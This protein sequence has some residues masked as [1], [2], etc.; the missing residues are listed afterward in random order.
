MEVEPKVDELP[1]HGPTVDFPYFEHLHYYDRVRDA[2]LNISYS[3]IREFTFGEFPRELPKDLD[4]NWTHTN[5]PE[6]LRKIIAGR[7]GT[8]ADHHLM[9]TGANEGNLVVNAALGKRGG[10]QRDESPI[11]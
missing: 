9:T 8:R 10:P 6:R 4:L 7:P 2:R 3:N 1:G 11:H 5:G